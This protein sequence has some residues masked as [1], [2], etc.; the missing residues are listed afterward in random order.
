MYAIVI[1]HNII[2]LNAYSA[3]RIPSNAKLH[4][5]YVNNAI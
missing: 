1:N 3:Y 2:E 4:F 5:K